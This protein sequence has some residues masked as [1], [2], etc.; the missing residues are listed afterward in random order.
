MDIK[1][2]RRFKKPRYSVQ[3]IYQRIKEVKDRFKQK[4]VIGISNE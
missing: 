1:N 4:N 2:K 3:Q